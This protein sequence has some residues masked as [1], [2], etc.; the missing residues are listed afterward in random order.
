[1]YRLPHL[2]REQFQRYW[3]EIHPRSAGPGAAG[4]LR[5]RRYVQLHTM[6]AES[7]AWLRASRNGPEEFD[8]VAEMWFDDE[9]DLRAAW[10]SEEGAAALRCMLEDERNFVDWGRSV[11]FVARE[12]AVLG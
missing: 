3:R 7:N 11:I 2:S 12:E 1:M 6:P 10:S 5:I 4:A 9:Q 8:G